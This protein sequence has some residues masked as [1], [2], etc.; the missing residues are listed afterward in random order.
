[1]QKDINFI[2]VLLTL[3]K[4]EMWFEFTSLSLSDGLILADKLHTLQ[5]FSPTL[6]LKHVL[7]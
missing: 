5:H 1:M 4:L 2:V 6:S 3:Q 7:Y